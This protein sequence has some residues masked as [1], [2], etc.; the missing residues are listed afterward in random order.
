MRLP[1][2]SQDITE[3]DPR[4]QLRALVQQCGALPAL[5]GAIGA[6]LDLAGD[7]NSSLDDLEKAIVCDLSCAARVLQTANSA[8]YG[9]GRAVTSIRRAILLLGFNLIRE[10]TLS[11][12][13]FDSLLTC[14]ADEIAAITGLSLHSRAVGALCRRIAYDVPSI[15][16]DLAFC[17]GLLHDLGRVVLLHLFP[18]EYSQCLI[19]LEETSDHN[20]IQIERELL[21]VS[22]TEAGFWLAEAWHLPSPLVRI[23]ARHHHTHSTHPLVMVVVL[24]DHIVKT[25]HIG[26]TDGQCSIDNLRRIA[27]TLNLSTRHLDQY[28]IYIQTEIDRV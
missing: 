23:I 1:T 2:Y 16:A 28:T 15:D 12:P 24:A 10:I 7:V 14:D 18:K 3:N 4:S 19:Q 13:A 9:S 21:G 8:F 17:A 27:R 5:P 25:Q 20:L 26:L 6:I 11:L 22:H